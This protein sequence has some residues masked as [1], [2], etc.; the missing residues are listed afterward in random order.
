[1]GDSGKNS[2][3]QCHTQVW[4]QSDDAHWTPRGRLPI[5]LSITP[6]TPEVPETGHFSAT[7]ECGTKRPCPSKSPGPITYI[8]KFQPKNPGRSP[9]KFNLKFKAFF[10]KLK[11]LKKWK[12]KSFSPFFDKRVHGKMVKIGKKPKRAKLIGII[13]N[14]PW[15]IQW[16]WSF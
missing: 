10:K 14:R 13:G 11:K 15:E 4:H 12:N 2:P 1:L 3:F 7:L 16:A 9:I 5:S 8:P 6:N